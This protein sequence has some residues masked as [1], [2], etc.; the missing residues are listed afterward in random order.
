[1]EEGE[2]AVL[3]LDGEHGRKIY[4][5]GRFDYLANPEFRFQNE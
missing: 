3:G 2:G 5:A 1:L 4:G